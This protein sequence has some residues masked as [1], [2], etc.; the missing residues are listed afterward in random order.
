MVNTEFR[1]DTDSVSSRSRDS[2][3]NR[4][5]RVNVGASTSRGTAGSNAP[6]GKPSTNAQ[7]P[8]CKLCSANHGL[9]H[10]TKFLEMPFAEKENTLKAHKLCEICLFFHKEGECRQP[11]RKC[12]KCN[13]NPPVFHNT[14]LC[15]TR[16]AERRTTLMSVV[17][18]APPPLTFPEK[19][20]KR[21]KR[22]AGR[23][24]AQ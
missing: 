14:L 18:N 5:N 21:P 16:E 8:P 4:R 1:D 20:R 15:P 19:P 7:L 22:G 11:K 9:Y 3:A 17:G 24:D 13:K 2:S 10:C 23:G 6:A 12:E